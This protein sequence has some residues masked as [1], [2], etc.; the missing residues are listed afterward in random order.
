MPGLFD[1]HCHL[2]SSSYENLEISKIL[3]DAKEAG[4]SKLCCVGY[5]FITSQ[6]AIEI[7]GAHHNVY[8]AIGIHP[9]DVS[10]HSLNHLDELT[11]MAHSNR[12]VGIG[13]IGLDYFHQK[14]SPEVQKKWFIAQLKI[15]LQ[16]DLPVIIHCRDAY[17]D[18][19]QILKKYNIK[20]GVMHCFLGTAR[21][22]QLFI[23]QGLLISFSGVVTFKN[24][25][26]LLETVKSV[27]VSH[28]VVETD[29]PYL[30]PAP[31]RGR[32]NFPMY[33]GYTAKKIADLKKINYEEFVRITSHN[34]NK[35]FTLVKEEE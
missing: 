25:G 21:E 2:M 31:Y 6:K 26:V 3:R 29:A 15:A 18:C 28:I 23:K 22:A 34:A 32:I 1:T 35:L 8:A 9:N 10:Q 12:I 11:K 14:T 30:A 17:S 19:L 13:E 24:A 16:F 27:P 33:I 4:V 5:D 7:A 20:R